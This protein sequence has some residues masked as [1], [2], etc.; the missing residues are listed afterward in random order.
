L[1][2][3]KKL[4]NRIGGLDEAQLKIFHFRLLLRRIVEDRLDYSNYLVVGRA[5]NNNRGRP[6]TTGGTP[7]MAEHFLFYGTLSTAGANA[8]FCLVFVKLF[9][10]PVSTVKVLPV[11][12]TILPK[13]IHF[14]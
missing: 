7:A 9:Y 2:E 8:L 3:N 10:L 12:S 5:T 1:D 6:T 11:F 13:E 14:P 4:D